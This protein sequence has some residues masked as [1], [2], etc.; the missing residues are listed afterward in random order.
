MKTVE[1]PV[2]LLLFVEQGDKPPIYQE[3]YEIGYDMPPITVARRGK[4]YEILDGNKR[5]RSAIA[6]KCTVIKAKIL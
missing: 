5:G 3:L 2:N 6:A 4:K 1:I